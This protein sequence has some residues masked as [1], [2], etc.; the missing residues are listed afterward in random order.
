MVESF[1]DETT[2]GIN[3]PLDIKIKL[4][5]RYSWVKRICKGIKKGEEE[6]LVFPVKMEDA[7]DEQ[8][9][10][11]FSDYNALV[12]RNA[13]EDEFDALERKVDKQVK[14]IASEEG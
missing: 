6:L 8:S 14:H 9:N 2:R 10:S 11:F 7:K 5:I 3:L 1:S 12:N 13:G 4:L